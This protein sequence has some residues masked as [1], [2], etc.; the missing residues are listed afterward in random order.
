MTSSWEQ[1]FRTWMGAGSDTEK[2]KR[3]HAESMVRDAIRND[4]TLS[5]HTLKVFAQ[6]SYRNNTNV[7]Q[8]SDVDICVCCMDVCFTDYT[9][10]DYG[11]TEAEMVNS[12]YRY[13]DLKNQVEQALVAKFGRA[14]VTRGNKAFDV[15]ANTYRVDADVVACFEYRRYNP[16][17]SSGR[18]TY[19]SGTRFLPD[20]G[21]SVINW[22][23]QHYANGVTKNKATGGRFKGVTRILKELRYQMEDDGIAAA[24]PIASFLIECL[25]WNTPSDQ[26]GHDLVSD[27]VRA[28]LIHTFNGTRDDEKCR[29]WL[30]V[31]ELKYLFRPSQPWTRQQANDFLKPAWNYVGFK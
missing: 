13:A 28:V 21:G 9:F 10:A 5:P 8:D 1:T 15:H 25:V 11:D 19:D 16:R 7:P 6:G 4:S 23:E 3:E 17:T 22:P 29:N 12:S 31:N 2:E 27:D 18:I 26:F 20:N 24:K 14:G 30:E